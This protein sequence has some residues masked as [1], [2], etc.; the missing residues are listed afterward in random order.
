M[1]MMKM[2]KE[3]GLEAGSSYNFGICDAKDIESYG[4]N[5]KVVEEWSYLE[6]DDIEPKILRL[7]RNIKLFSRV[8]WTIRAMIN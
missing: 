7:F 2:K 5:I 3:L 4:D 8:Q 1:V 6:D